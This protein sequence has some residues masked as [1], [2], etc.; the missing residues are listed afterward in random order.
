MNKILQKIQ[1]ARQKT[2][3]SHK[4]EEWA[5]FSGKSAGFSSGKH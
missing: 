4:R 5:V 2:I 3:F 1:Q